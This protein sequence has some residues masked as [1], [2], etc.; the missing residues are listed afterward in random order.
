[1]K[2]IFLS[3]LLI[4]FKKALI[5]HKIDYKAITNWTLIKGFLNLGLEEMVKQFTMFFFKSSDWIQPVSPRV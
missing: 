4:P 2:I 3:M 1:M 5:D